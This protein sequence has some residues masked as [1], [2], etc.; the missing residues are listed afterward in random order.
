MNINRAR[1]CHKA[2]YALALLFSL[3]TAWESCSRQAR[4]ED[5]KSVRSAGRCNSVNPTRLYGRDPGCYFEGCQ[6]GRW[7]VRSPSMVVV[8]EPETHDVVQVIWEGETVTGLGFR[9]YSR[10]LAYTVLRNFGP[11]RANETI[12]EVLEWSS[13]GDSGSTIVCARGKAYDIYPITAST[14]A[15]CR[16]GMSFCWAKFADLAQEVLARDIHSIQH[17]WAKVR[18]A[19]GKLGW[20]NLEESRSFEGLD[21]FG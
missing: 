18:L 15:G 20:V 16:D 5:E 6:L 1:S 2:A 8:K 10:P 3:G 19:N 4:A 7:T 11:F 17:H 21:A 13:E 12:H 9:T 14:I